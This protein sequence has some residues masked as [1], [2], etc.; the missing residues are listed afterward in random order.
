MLCRRQGFQIP[1]DA[2]PQARW[3]GLT[4]VKRRELEPGDLLYFGESEEK[5]TH[6]GLYIGGGEFIHATAYRKPAIQISELDEPHWSELL[7]ACRRLKG[8]RR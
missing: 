1:R 6:T 2:G 7:V 8:E 4:A 3:D 5:I